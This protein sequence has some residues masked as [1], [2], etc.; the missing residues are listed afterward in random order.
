[1]SG[2]TFLFVVFLAGAAVT[3]AAMVVGRAG[4]R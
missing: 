4:G 1:M 3:V 2:I